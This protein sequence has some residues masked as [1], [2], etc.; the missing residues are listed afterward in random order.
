MNKMMTTY[1]LKYFFVEL[2]NNIN[3]DIEL[4]NDII[5]V[6]GEESITP[7]MLIKTHSAMRYINNNYEYDFIVRSNLSS[8]W[9]IPHLYEIL[10]PFLNN[11]IATGYVNTFRQPSFISGTGIILSKDVC[12]KLVEYINFY[13]DYEDV[14][15]SSF[16]LQFTNIYSLPNNKLQFL[17]DGKNN[18]IPSD[19][20]NIL[21]FRIKSDGDREHDKITFK[22]L[23]KKIYDIDIDD[24]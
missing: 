9:N 2:K 18:I 24:L 11:N 22:L 19:V 14:L 12:I 16:I 3:N 10:E 17:I 6:K 23:A 21:Y 4:I 7:G 15:I 20:S 8:F 1:S 13:N 5:Y